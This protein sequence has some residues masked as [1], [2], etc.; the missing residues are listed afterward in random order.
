MAIVAR[1][2]DWKVSPTVY[3]YIFFMIFCQPREC[4]FSF[5]LK[6]LVY[7]DDQPKIQLHCCVMS[8]RALLNCFCMIH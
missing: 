8:Q 5:H 4:K 1:S 7:D 2:F 6:M 3:M